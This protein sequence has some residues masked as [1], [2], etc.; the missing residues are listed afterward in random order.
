MDGR[1]VS[2]DGNG[3]EQGAAADLLRE[4]WLSQ[5]VAL[6]VAGEVAG[7]LHRPARAFERRL[8]LGRESLAL[9]RRTL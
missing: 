4:A 2:A 1:S 7:D 6:D 8:A 3:P 9:Q 5:A